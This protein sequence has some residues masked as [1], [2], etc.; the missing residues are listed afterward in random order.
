MQVPGSTLSPEALALRTRLMADG[1]P[2]EGEE[3]ALVMKKLDEL[4]DS[5]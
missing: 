3:R 4:A 2:L 1:A 5:L